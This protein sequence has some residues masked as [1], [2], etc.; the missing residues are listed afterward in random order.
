MVSKMGDIVP[1][2]AIGLRAIFFH[3][4]SGSRYSSALLPV[5]DI[6]NPNPN[7]YINPNCNPD[8]KS[9]TRQAWKKLRGPRR[10]GA[11]E[12]AGGPRIAVPLTC[13]VIFMHLGAWPVR[14]EF[15]RQNQR[16][17]NSFR[18][19][20]LLHFLFTS[21]K[22]VRLQLQGAIERTE[23]TTVEEDKK[24]AGNHC[25]SALLCYHTMVTL[26]HLHTSK[27][28]KTVRKWNSLHGTVA[29][30]LSDHHNNC[31]AIIFTSQ[32]SP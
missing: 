25:D 14:P 11:K 5:Q 1:Q 10:G 22:K 32:N 3:A 27:R 30:I 2:R 23:T 21:L 9:R 15:D 26:I 18:H 31:L 8:R 4:C 19:F 29:Q 6:H 7:P 20:P 13:S 16:H 12:M 28:K 24:K 17:E